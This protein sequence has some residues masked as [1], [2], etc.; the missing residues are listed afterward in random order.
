MPSKIPKNILQLSINN[1]NTLKS[2][3]IRREKFA[4]N[5]NKSI[6]VGQEYLSKIFS[7]SGI[8]DGIDNQIPK[9]IRGIAPEK[10]EIILDILKFDPE[11][12]IVRPEM[13]HMTRSICDFLK[14]NNFEIKFLIRKKISIKEYY[15]LY[16]KEIIRNSQNF[17]S[18][19]PSRTL[20]YINAKSSIIILTKSRY[21]FKKCN[22]H[23]A[24]LFSVKFKGR[25]GEKSI[26]TIRGDIIYNEAIR[27]GFNK[28]NNR[29][30]VAAIDPF[31]IYGELIKKRTG[32]Y[33]HLRT[34][35]Q[36]YALMYTGQGIHCS[37]YVELP[38]DLASILNLKQ[39]IKLKF[40]L[41][42]K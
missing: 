20:A 5:L 30:I 1:R 9:G 11:L 18:I 14:K 6:A 40:N 37:T 13:Y 16:K 19:L 38:N 3:K 34:S 33:Y 28:L 27:L 41:K 7:K 23:F 35:P 39:L 25:E 10:R 8:D 36:N 17:R 12:I 4:G 21:N 32:N 2:H 26:N 15:N 42:S 31:E 24:D 29:T 22:T